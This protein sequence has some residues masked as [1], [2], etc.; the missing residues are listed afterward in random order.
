M[1]KQEA[2]IRSAQIRL[3]DDVFVGTN[4]IILKGVSIGDLS[5]VAA[6]ALVFRGNYPPDSTTA[7]NPPA[8]VREKTKLL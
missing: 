3:G 7:C 6:G 2:K 8:V 5:I 4:A 1:R